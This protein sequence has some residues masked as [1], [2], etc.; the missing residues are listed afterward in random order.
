MR[1][2][3]ILCTFGLLLARC[4]PSISR[5]SSNSC[6]RIMGK[7]KAGQKLACL[8]R[9]LETLFTKWVNPLSGHL[10][11]MVLIL[12]QQRFGITLR[13]EI[14]DLHAYKI[15]INYLKFYMEWISEEEHSVSMQYTNTVFSKQEQRRTCHLKWQG[16]N[17]PVKSECCTQSSE[18]CPECPLGKGA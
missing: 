16:K 17:L 6:L 1:A 13:M 11:S 12:S 9:Y 7:C 2:H 4:L 18:M 15:I 10:L 8:G 3:F 14:A 5:I